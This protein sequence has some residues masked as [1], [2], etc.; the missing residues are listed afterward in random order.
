ME[1]KCNN[2]KILK[3]HFLDFFP[4]LQCFFGEGK[5]KKIKETRKTSLKWFQ[6]KD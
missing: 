2:D 1:G 6:R 5:K 4:L 3:I